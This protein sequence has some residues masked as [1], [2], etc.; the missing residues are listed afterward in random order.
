MRFYAIRRQ[1]LII[2]SLLIVLLFTVSEI[3]FA[4]ND[5]VRSHNEI[6]ALSFSRDSGFFEFPF[7]LE[8]TA[9]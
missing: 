9:W 6:P 1:R 3:F 5:E 2:G 7:E 8:L 4:G